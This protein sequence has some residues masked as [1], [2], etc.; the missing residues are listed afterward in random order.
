M[1]NTF[2]SILRLTIIECPIWKNAKLILVNI[3]GLSKSFLI[4]DCKNGSDINGARQLK[5][6]NH[7][8]KVFK[9]AMVIQKK[10]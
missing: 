3:T 5:T 6:K 8:V 2:F 1:K 9:T 4:F 10:F 7:L